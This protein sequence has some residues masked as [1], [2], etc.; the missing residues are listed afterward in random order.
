M[1]CSELFSL[2]RNG[3]EQ[4][5]ESLLLFLYHGKEFWVVFS[6]PEGFLE[7]NSESCFYFC[8][9]E[10]N[11]KL[12]S[13]PRK[14]LELN[15]ESFLFSFRLVFFDTTSRFWPCVH[16]SNGKTSIVR[17]RTLSFFAFRFLK[18]RMFAFFRDF[19][20]KISIEPVRFASI[21]VH[22]SN[23]PVRFASL[24]WFFAI[25]TFASLR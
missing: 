14:S 16:A 5:S 17:Y 9:T 15:S 2:P 13:L 3:L 1:L 23:K 4:P 20:C 11:S 8:S 6:S 21:L 7:R 12:F 10:R 19:K 18:K 24:I 25:T 22:V